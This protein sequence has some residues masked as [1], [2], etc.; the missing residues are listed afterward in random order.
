MS[1]TDLQSICP[2]IKLTQYFCLQ[3]PKSTN[4]KI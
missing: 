4:E 1:A 2:A 3:E